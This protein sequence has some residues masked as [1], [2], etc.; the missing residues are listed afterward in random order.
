MLSIQGVMFGIYLSSKKK[1]FFI[2]LF[3]QGH[4]SVQLPVC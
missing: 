2:Q 4:K 3:S 1:V